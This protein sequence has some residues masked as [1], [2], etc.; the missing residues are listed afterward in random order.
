MKSASIVLLGLTGALAACGGA[1]APPPP[2]TAAAQAPQPLPNSNIFATQIRT[3][4]KAKNVQNV[5]DQRKANTDKQLQD[6]EGH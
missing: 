2:P 3:L 6:A 4:D 1:D 5:M